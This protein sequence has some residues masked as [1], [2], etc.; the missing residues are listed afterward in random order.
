M[1][2]I[3]DGAGSSTAGMPKPLTINC[4]RK[5]SVMPKTAGTTKSRRRD[6]RTSYAV[7]AMSERVIADPGEHPEKCRADPEQRSRR[8][9]RAARIDSIQN[10]MPMTT[11]MRN[12]RQGMHLPQARD[13]GRAPMSRAVMRSMTPISQTSTADM[14]AA[15]KSAAQIWIVW[16]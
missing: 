7:V 4:Q 12:E 16:P 11:S 1:V 3:S 13:H 10:R 8:S 6:Q 5:S 9:P 14:M 2:Q 15:A